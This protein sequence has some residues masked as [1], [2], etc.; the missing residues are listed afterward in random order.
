MKRTQ[1]LFLLLITLLLLAFTG[2]TQEPVEEEVEALAPDAFSISLEPIG[3]WHVFSPKT[4]LFTATDAATD[5]GVAGLDFTVQI[6]RAESDRV[7]ERTMADGDVVDEGDGVYAVEYTPSSIGAYSVA[8]TF[9]KD[10]QHFASAPTAFEV[11]KAGEEGIKASANGTD[12]V[13]QIRYHFEPG[14]VH[15]N[16][17]EPVKLVFELMRGVETGDAINWEQPWTNTFDHV[18]AVEEAE[19]ALTSEDGAVSDSLTPTYSGRG[20]W[21][22]ERTFPEAEV[23]E[24]MEY[25]LNL[26]FADSANGAAVGHEEPFHLH[27]VPGH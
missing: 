4:L 12:Y 23:G 26:S 16:D 8:A 1:A 18:T 7:S 2:C 5:Q 22:A 19:I 3:H 24:G 13:Y 10:G 6:V 9:V 25:A 14:H 27:A 15:A 21:E 11:A 17:S 20:I